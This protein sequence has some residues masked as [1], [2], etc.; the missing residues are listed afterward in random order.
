MRFHRALFFVLPVSIVACSSSSS[1]P[2]GGDAGNGDTGVVDTGIDVMSNC[3]QP[4]DQGNSLGVGHFCLSS[5]D[6]LSTS[7][8]H[9]CSNLDPTSQTYFC[10]FICPRPPDA[11]VEGGAEGGA[12][13]AGDPCGENA[14]C[15]CP[16]SGPCGCT[17]STCL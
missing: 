7:Q 15:V 10:T 9:L 13:D 6:C 4:G 14:A 17:P 3:G 11:G 5:N 12:G 8:A 16:S 2:P 1:T